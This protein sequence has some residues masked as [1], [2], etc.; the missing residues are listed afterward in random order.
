VTQLHNK[1]TPSE[2]RI[3]I[4]YL[5]PEVVL[6]TSLSWNGGHGEHPTPHRITDT[7]SIRRVAGCAKE[8]RWRNPSGY[9]PL[10]ERL[11]RCWTQMALRATPVVQAVAMRRAPTSSRVGAIPSS[12]SAPLVRR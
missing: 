3:A 4:T 6:Q 9:D 1:S 7:A 11:E 8:K 2:E 5:L 12:R 10:M